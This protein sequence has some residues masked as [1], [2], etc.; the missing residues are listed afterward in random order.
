MNSTTSPVRIL[1]TDE[2]AKP[3]LALRPREAAAALG[4]SPR[5]L[6]DWTRRG[7]MPHF[8]RGGLVLYPVAGLTRWLEAQ[9]QTAPAAK[10]GGER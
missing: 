10:E 2:P 9:T 7:D 3:C 6:W 5:T 8:R 1:D 4:V